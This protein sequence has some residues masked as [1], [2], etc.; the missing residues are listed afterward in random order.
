MV[1]QDGENIAKQHQGYTDGTF[2]YYKKDAAWH[3]IHPA[4]GL[5]IC[6]SYTRKKA[7]ERANEPVMLQRIAAALERQQEAAE[8]FTAAVEKA[9]EAAA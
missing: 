9:K 3:V 8:R 4:N 5:S 1:R 2:Y 7:A 6:S